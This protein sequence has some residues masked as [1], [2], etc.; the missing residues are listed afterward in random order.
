MKSQW[1]SLPP[2][3]VLVSCLTYWTLKMVVI[4]SSE[5]LVDFQWTTR[6]YIPEDNILHNHRCENLKSYKIEVNYTLKILILL[7]YKNTTALKSSGVIS[8][9][10]VEPDTVMVDC[11]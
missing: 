10:N 9:I 3:F 7:N 2:A 6:R 8:C 4:Y 1:H 11:P 5:M